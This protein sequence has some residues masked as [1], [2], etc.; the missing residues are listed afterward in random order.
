M[1]RCS[2]DI[3]VQDIIGTLIAG[4]TLIML[5]PKGNVEFEY[6]TSVFKDKKVTFM[7]TVPSLLNSFFN[8]LIM[9][10]RLYTITSLRSLCSIG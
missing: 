9:A 1:S 7:H 8:F 6:L 3:H 5:H 10:N 2:F 4:A